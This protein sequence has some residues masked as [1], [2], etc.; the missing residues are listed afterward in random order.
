MLSKNYTTTPPQVYQDLQGGICAMKKHSQYF[1]FFLCLKNENKSITFIILTFKERCV[2]LMLNKGGN[3]LTKAEIPVS[4]RVVDQIV[5][6]AFIL[7]QPDPSY[8]ILCN[9]SLSSWEVRES[10]KEQRKQLWAETR[11]YQDGCDPK[12][13]TS[14]GQ[15]DPWA[16]RRAEKLNMRFSN[17]S[18][19]PK[20]IKPSQV[21]TI[22]QKHT[23]PQKA[24]LGQIQICTD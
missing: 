6:K 19:D 14:V 12:G 20:G 16:S 7:Q 11:K 1:N 17:N 5:Q 21:A 13:N 2:T 24:S 23:L 9:V 4:S 3:R 22:Q 15:T 10:F 8:T 18:R